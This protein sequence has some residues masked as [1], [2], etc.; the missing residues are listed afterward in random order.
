[1]VLERLVAGKPEHRIVSVIWAVTSPP[2]RLPLNNPSPAT[3]GQE[4]E[5]VAI[6]LTPL[7]AEDGEMAPETKPA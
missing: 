2:D 4:G 7:T 3:L 1:M 5:T 6:K